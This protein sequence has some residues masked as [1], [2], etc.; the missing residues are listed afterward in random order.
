MP[1]PKL[2]ELEL[3][4]FRGIPTF[5][6]KFGG[7]SLI[8]CGENG[9]GKS[10]LVDGLE[11]LLTGQIGHLEGVQG[12]STEKHGPHAILGPQNML[13]SAEFEGLDGAVSRSPE[14]EPEVPASLQRMFKVANTS[15]FILHRRELLEFIES[16]DSMRYRAISGILG[17][18]SLDS[19]EMSMK[20]AKERI[21]VRLGA[22]HEQYKG[23]LERMGILLDSEVADRTQVLGAVNRVMVEFGANP[24]SKM[25]DIALAVKNLKAS[26]AGGS[27]SGKADLR[28]NLAK[29]EDYAEDLSED[30]SISVLAD[31]TNSAIDELIG[32]GGLARLQEQTL[33]N[34]GITILQE[35]EYTYCPL[36]LQQISRDAVLASLNDRQKTLA[37][38]TAQATLIRR[39]CT[40][41]VDRIVK[42]E[43]SAMEALSLLRLLNAPD[44]IRA[45]ATQIVE[46]HPRLISM[47]RSTSDIAASLD[48]D[49]LERFQSESAAAKK[50]I[51]A[52]VKHEHASM[53]LTKVE[54]KRLD[55]LLT[56]GK[57]S[58]GWQRLVSL[59]NKRKY[60]SDKR[61][62]AETVF[63]TFVT[64]KN[65]KLQSIFDKI[66]SDVSKYYDRLHPGESHENVSLTVLR[67]AS[68]SLKIDSFG[69][70]RVEPRAYASEGHLDSLGLCVFLA[71]ARSFNDEVG[72]LVLDDVVT[73]IDRSHRRLICDL[74]Y[75]EFSDKQ[76]LI[77]THDRVWFEEL[78]TRLTRY[79]LSGEFSCVRIVA[80]DVHS[81]PRFDDY[82]P[83]QETIEARIESG[84]LHGAGNEC[85]RFLEWLLLEACIATETRVKLRRDDRHELSE[86]LD[87]LGK[88]LKDL[89]SKTEVWP[90]LK[91]AIQSLRE[92]SQ[93]W[94]WLS[95]AGQSGYELSKVEIEVL[96]ECTVSLK[97]L[98]SCPK[99]G[100]LL[101][102]DGRIKRYQCINRRC[103]S[104]STL[105]TK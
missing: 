88:R 53:Q 23:E 57:T 98:L 25:E 82:R 50:A 79:G 34:A 41:L 43:K 96:L 91:E 20:R 29:L 75:S 97:Q 49:Q 56:L 59:D 36:C 21:Q 101:N 61:A 32:E 24:M 64:T 84:D 9:S 103:D 85:R 55:L 81:G 11:F 77:T 95:H 6:R 39:N 46:Q 40:L 15:K 99:C 80:W 16:Q 54:D 33:V 10:S 60:L 105:R 92:H 71:F 22:T 76:L 69:I 14:F 73:S 30:A 44:S 66:E 93:F 28:V 5:K 68:L 17:V 4:A 94:N 51:S 62:I 104:C 2:I 83:D 37:Q 7:K 47:V 65:E 19:V 90:A 48:R 52:Y 102:Y 31:E 89:L 42:I 3:Q 45:A 67:R 87:R 38:L 70:S 86:L 58:E 8:V 78:R 1:S 13:V 63:N 12:L 100:D 74:L 18:A 35:Y 72:L 26:V 27:S